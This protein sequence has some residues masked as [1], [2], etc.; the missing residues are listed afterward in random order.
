MNSLTVTFPIPPKSIP[1]SKQSKYGMVTG[2]GSKPEA[3]L[4]LATI[5][6]GWMRAN[7]PKH[8]FAVDF[9]GKSFPSISNTK[10]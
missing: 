5:S 3:A 9:S 2:S 6:A 1:V 10:V 8:K 7:I 4:S